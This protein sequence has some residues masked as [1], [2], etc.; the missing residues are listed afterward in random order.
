MYDFNKWGIIVPAADPDN[1]YIED[2]RNVRYIYWVIVLDISHKLV[3]C[4]ESNYVATQNLLLPSLLI[5][6]KRNDN[7]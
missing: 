4:T 7:T 3:I 5:V 2:S 1:M 6:N